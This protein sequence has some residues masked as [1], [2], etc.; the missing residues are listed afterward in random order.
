MKTH[1]HV[2]LGA[3]LCTL[4]TLSACSQADGGSAAVSAAA[5]TPSEVKA[6]KSPEPGAAPAQYQAKV[7]TLRLLGTQGEGGEASATLADT[8]TWYTRTYRLGE[9]L[10]R[11]LK[12]TAVR[13]SELELSDNG[14]PPRI[15]RAG[16]DV[17]LR[18]IEHEFDTAAV[19]RGEHQ[20]TVKAAAMARLLSRYGIGAT[21]TPIEFA[22]RAGIKLGAVQ[23]GSLLARLG[24]QKGDLLFEL[25]GK[26]A[27]PASLESLAAEATQAKSQVITVQMARGASLWERAYVI[28]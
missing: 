12:L 14:A 4:S 21:A 2:L 17:Q 19:E 3:T 20:W 24:M 25:S 26:P 7:V 22:G 11:N 28:E 16:Q 9:T 27:T 10:G 13:D 8:T 6:L 18:L 5:V 23:P 1:I 15:V